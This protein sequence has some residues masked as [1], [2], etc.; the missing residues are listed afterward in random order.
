MLI[1]CKTGHFWHDEHQMAG[2]S[3][4]RHDTKQFLQD[5]EMEI[6]NH[7][8]RRGQIRQDVQCDAAKFV[9]SF[10]FRG[11]LPLGRLRQGPWRHTSLSS[12]VPLACFKIK[13]RNTE[14]VR[15]RQ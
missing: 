5:R 15:C 8:M 1:W 14:R 3:A 12:F 2:R 9:P 7:T 13:D 11:R 4:R 10:D 6:G